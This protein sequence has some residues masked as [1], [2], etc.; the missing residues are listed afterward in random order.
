MTIHQ[1]KGLEF[2]VVVVG[3]LD[4]SSR[5]PRRSTGTSAPSTT[6]RRS[7]RRAGS[8]SFDRMRLHYVAFSR[9]EKV[10]VLTTDEPPKDHFAPIWQGLPQWPYVETGGARRPALRDQGRMPVKKSFSFTGDLKVYETC[11][12]QYQFFRDYDFTPSPLG[13]D[14]LR[15]AGPPDD[16]GDPPP[17]ARRQARHRSTRSASVSLFERTFRIL[18]QSDVRPIGPGAKESAFAQVMN[19]FRQNREEMRAGRRDRGRRLGREG[20]LHPHGQGGSPARRRR[21][22][23]DA[24]LQDRARSP[25][26]SPS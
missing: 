5:A 11:P 14:L 6:G 8:R 24:R 4:A 17:R 2:P 21:Q 18:S 15:P 19:Y 23:R 12:R 10:L 9:P 20:R 3:S 22:A 16:R 25:V 7:S 1:A 26:D 13:G